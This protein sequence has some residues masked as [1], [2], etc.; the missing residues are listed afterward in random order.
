MQSF[1]A[2]WRSCNSA[3]RRIACCGIASAL[4]LGWSPAAVAGP[5]LDPG[6]FFHYMLPQRSTLQ[7]RVRNL[8]DT[9]AFVQIQLAEMTFDEKGAP[10]ERELRTQDGFDRAL[11]VTPPRMIIPA[12][13][14]QQVRVI[15]RGPRTQE[16]YFR[17]RYVPVMPKAN[18]AFAL[19]PGE[20]RAYAD[21]IQAGVGVLKA[22]GTVIIVGPSEPRYYTRLETTEKRLRI[23]NQ[24]NATV[25]VGNASYCSIKTDTCKGETTAHIRPGQ[26]L[27]IP[28]RAGEV[29]R[30]ELRE[31]ATH[32]SHVYPQ[33]K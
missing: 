15:Y 17:V 24:G 27:D 14:S 10:H 1:D 16:R 13:G 26:H 25:R 18:D 7:A 33:G 6:T 9:A 32:T 8:G 29:Y 11:L 21:A 12:D 23:L 30:F 31:G 3:L 28:Q 20:A 19:Q 2:T 5:D 4:F 22:I